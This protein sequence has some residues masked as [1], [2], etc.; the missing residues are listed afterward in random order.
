MTPTYDHDFS[1]C[2]GSPIWGNSQLSSFHQVMD[3]F[4]FSLKKLAFRMVPDCWSQGV[5]DVKTE[6]EIGENSGRAQSSPNLHF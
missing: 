3:F 4:Y 2:Q 6:K 1:N 5:V